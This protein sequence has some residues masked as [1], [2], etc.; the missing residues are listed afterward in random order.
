MIK[1]DDDQ[2]TIRITR[3]DCTNSD[4]NRL[5]FYFPIWDFENEEET[6]YHFVG[7]DIITLMIFREKGYT[8]PSMEKNWTITELGYPLGTDT[9]ELILDK[10]ITEAF[11]LSNKKQTFYYQIILNGD[12]T[13]IGPDEDGDPKI[14]VYPGGMYEGG[15]PQ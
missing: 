7:S 10:T 4:Y 6:R 13:I 5:A 11:E 1:I 15:R 12:T 3:G 2:R 9:P 14:I 8:K